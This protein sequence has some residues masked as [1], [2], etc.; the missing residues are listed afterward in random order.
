MS[1]E[2]ERLFGDQYIYKQ[3]VPG[4]VFCSDSIGLSLLM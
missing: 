1:F 3:I 4:I 2:V